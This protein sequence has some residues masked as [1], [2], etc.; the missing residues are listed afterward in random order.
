[1][2]DEPH[3]ALIADDYDIFTRR[4]RRDLRR[5]RHLWCHWRVMAKEGYPFILGCLLPAVAFSVLNWWV[6][7]VPCILLTL[8]MAYFFRDPERAIPNDPN[9]VVS[10]ADGKV[11]RVERVDP[12]NPDSP[13]LVPTF[14]RW[15]S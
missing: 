6:A 13:I 4:E 12:G 15:T 8:F 9:A 10:P 5:S 3:V 11:T 14:R 7:A 2:E 1:M